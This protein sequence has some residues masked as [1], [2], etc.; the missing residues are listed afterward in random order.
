MVPIPYILVKSICLVEVNMFARF[1]ENPAMTLQDI[2]EAKRWTDG[3]TDGCTDNVKTVYTPQT[4]F[5]VG[6]M[7]ICISRRFF[8][9]HK[10]RIL[11]KGHRQTMHAQ[12]RCRQT[13]RLIRVSTVCL[14]NFLL[15]FENNEKKNTQQPLTQKWTG[16]IESNRKFH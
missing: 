2:K 7:I 5:A 1:D 15:I 16:Q 10:P 3:W 4:H 12:I 14:H 11:F 8:N 9:P 13:R 6:L